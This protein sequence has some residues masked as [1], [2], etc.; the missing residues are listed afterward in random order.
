MCTCTSTPVSRG[1]GRLRGSSSRDVR[2][3]WR[4]SISPTRPAE[5]SRSAPRRSCRCPMRPCAFRRSMWPSVRERRA[6]GA[7][8]QPFA[9]RAGCERSGPGVARAAAVRRR[10]QQLQDRQRRADRARGRGGRALRGARGRRE[11]CRRWRCATCVRCASD[12]PWRR[13]R[14]ATGS[15]GSRSAT[16]AAT[17]ASPFTPS[18]E[19]RAFSGAAERRA[20]PPN[21]RSGAAGRGAARDVAERQARVVRALARHAEHALADDVAGHLGRAAADARRLPHQEG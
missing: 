10:V 7:A 1:V 18:R 17:T 2:C 20:P 15:A 3:S 11:R 21:C 6:T 12:R 8:R 19:R 14:C 16:V 13:L 5:T 4:W 9:E